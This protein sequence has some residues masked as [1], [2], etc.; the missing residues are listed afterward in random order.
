MRAL[1]AEIRSAYP[2]LP[3]RGAPHAFARSL[4][5]AGF[6]AAMWGGACLSLNGDAT[7]TLRI[8]VAGLG[9]DARTGGLVIASRIDSVTPPRIVPIPAGGIDSVSIPVGTYHVAYSTPPR[10]LLAPGSVNLRTAQVVAG[11]LT[12]ASFQVQLDTG[13]AEPDLLD[14]ASF[15]TGW[16][17]FM[18]WSL[19]SSPSPAAGIFSITRSQDIAY[20]GAWSV[21]STFGPSDLEQAV[22]F[23]YRFG[24]QVDV[25][26]RVYFYI[27]GN[28]PTNHHKWIRFQTSGFNGVQGGLYLATTTGGVTW[29]DIASRP[30]ANVDIPV[31]IGVPTFNAWHSIEVE[32]DR[33]AWNTPFGPRVRFWYDGAV[34][35]GRN[36]RGTAFWGGDSGTPSVNGPWLYIGAPA[37]ALTPSA[38]LVIDDTY[39][40]GN[41]NS[42]TFYYD[43]IAISTQRIGP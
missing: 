40:A 38:I 4:L 13:F 8:A 1:L 12:T 9:Q 7:G 16:D 18:D 24:N 17:G 15:E 10:Y 22:Q 27:A 25:Y 34:T 23:A 26:A 37:R 5:S 43:R 42:G 33:S 20:D 28:V 11:H 36:P 2:R 31:G 14:N 29:A 35:V 19:T 30:D 41:T 21:K 39:N 32:Y 6:V 3:G